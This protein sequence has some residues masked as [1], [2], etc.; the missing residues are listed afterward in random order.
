MTKLMI[1]GEAWGKDE[2]AEGRPFVGASGRLLNQMLS[3]AGIDREE[4]YVTNVLNLRPRPSND[5]RNCCGSKADG[6]PNM[7][8]LSPGKYLRQEYAGELARLYTEVEKVSPNLV[9][10][11]G[12]TAA[13]AFL[14]TSGISKIRG[15][16]AESYRGVKVLPTYHPAAIMRDWTLRPIVIA[17]LHKAKREQEF[18]EV[19][20]PRREVWVEP[21]LEDLQNFA[22]KHIA[23]ADLVCVDIETIGDMITCVGIAPDPQYAIVIPFSSS[24]CRAWW[25]S[26]VS[27]TARSTRMPIVRQRK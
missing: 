26:M 21:T 15:S 7:P 17:D 6:I 9:L 16:T 25:R 14:R 24:G 3:M 4:C 27:S 23:C 8:A 12:A 18:P 20:R 5:I 19:R 22:Y 1:V 10:A 2:E 11:F 13:W